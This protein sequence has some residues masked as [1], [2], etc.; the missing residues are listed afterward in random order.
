MK[1]VFVLISDKNYLEHAKSL[2]LYPNEIDKKSIDIISNEA[3]IDDKLLSCINIS[4]KLENAMI[5]TIR[6]CH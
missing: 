5:S 2:F 3:N 4:N 1:K 6:S